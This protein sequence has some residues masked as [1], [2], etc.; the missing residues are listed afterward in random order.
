MLL[1]RVFY[2][3][4]KQ[5]ILVCT[6]HAEVYKSYPFLYLLL[7]FD[8]LLFLATSR[9]IVFSKLHLRS[10]ILLHFPWLKRK[11]KTIRYSPLNPRAI[12]SNPQILCKK[13]IKLVSV[14]RLVPYKD[15]YS[16]LVSLSLLPDNYTL[17]II[18]KGPLYHSLIEHA[19]SLGVSNRV[20]ISTCLNDN[21]LHASLSQSTVFVLASN[22]QS[23]AYGIVQLEALQ[24]GL[25]CVVSYLNNG[26]NSIIDPGYSGLFSIPSNPQSIAKA[27]LTITD[28]PVRYHHFTTNALRTARRYTIDAMLAE[29]Q[30]LFS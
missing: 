23:E 18:G 5:P 6:W 17:H 19:H 26:T 25:P 7:P 8:L 10:S 22:S 4:K 24:H 30:D 15:H 3:G 2:L 14:G 9:I 27:I 1:L 20:T 28:S 11:T 29:Y 13:N 12:S 16:L 21:Q